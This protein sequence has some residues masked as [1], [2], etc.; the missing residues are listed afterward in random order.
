MRIAKALLN[1]VALLLM[2]IL[3]VSGC[4]KS[5]KQMVA[6]VG[7]RKITIN[8]FEKK[9]GEGRRTKDV[10]NAT[11]DE[12]KKFLEKMIDTKLKLISA[13]QNDLNK[14]ENV[15]RLINE[16]KKTLLFRRLV[17]KEV[18]EK[19]IPESRIK[20][21]YKRASKEVKISQIVL[22]NTDNSAEQKK[23]NLIRARKIVRRIKSGEKFS[24]LAKEVSNDL[25]TAKD[26]GQKGYL[27]W[28][29][30]SY[31]NPVY[32]AAFSMKNGEVSD[33]IE[34]ENGVY[35][36]K[37]IHVKKY[38]SPPYEQEREKIK[39]SIYRKHNKEIEQAYY[40]FLD[41][42]KVKYKLEYDNKAISFFVKTLESKNKAKASDGDAQQPKSMSDNFDK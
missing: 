40:E 21:Y 30:T 13:Y 18:M 27:K 38:P 20:N 35:I 7:G 10:Q 32:V 24:D 31:K 16:R 14:D 15:A 19:I 3:L 11:L 4:G 42:L 22:K 23:Q 36:I 12:K 28:G 25:S 8:D 41:A 26:G 1:K 6:R 5:D 29:V 2:G 39:Q 33:P 34:V 37:V 9:F 17:E